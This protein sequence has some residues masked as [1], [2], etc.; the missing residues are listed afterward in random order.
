MLGM[1]ILN[2]NIKV[3]GPVML[4]LISSS[5]RKFIDID[6][7]K[8]SITTEYVFSN[9]KS[10][11]AA[12]DGMYT[13][14]ANGS[15]GGLSFVNGHLSV[16]CGLSADELY[17]FT[18]NNALEQFRSNQLASNNSIISG[19][20][21]TAYSNIY[22]AN[23]CV[24]NL[25][26]NKNIDPEIRKRLTGESKFI[27]AYNYLYLIQLLEKVPLVTSIE[28]F[29][30][31][32]FRHASKDQIYSQIIADLTDAEQLLSVEY[33]D[34]NKGRPN[35][36]AAKALLARAYLYK[37]DWVNAEGSATQ[38]IDNAAIYNLNMDLDS[39]FLKNNNEALWQLA[40]GVPERNTPE[41]F[42]FIPSTIPTYVLTNELLAAFE[43]GDKRRTS[44]VGEF[45][46]MGKSYFFPF[47]YKIKEAMTV[48]EYI[49]LLRLA[50]T[51]LIRAEARA[52]QSKLSDATSDIN[53][54]R[55]RAGLEV[56]QNFTDKALCLLA[57]EQ[58]RRIEFFAEHGHRW[59]D[60]GRTNRATAVL[61]PLKA[62]WKPTDRLYPIPLSEITKS[63]L[64]QNDGY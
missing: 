30:T 36:W 40:P 13:A 7:P 51:Y 61:S 2:N 11:I 15:F 38:V 62:N 37:G 58:E 4:F 35:R 43:P 33:V 60:L 39:N 6:P 5:C 14:M 45:V 18:P 63:F 57:I 25:T 16:L 48:E 10:A 19:L 56:L 53:V 9:N 52:N 8:N 12:V 1:K 24:T 17:H 55:K 44:W 21:A 41:G 42:N 49:T 22:Q 27:R 31:A 50:E 47:K 32:N 3:L 28:Y 29:E 20:W 23:A 34:M 26:D 54:I 64:E 59:I 46:Y